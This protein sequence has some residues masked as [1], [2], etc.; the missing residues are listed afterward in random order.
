MNAIGRNIWLD[1]FMFSIVGCGSDEKTAV[2]KGDLRQIERKERMAADVNEKAVLD[3]C[4]YMVG[5]QKEMAVNDEQI[6]A[7]RNSEDRTKRYSAFY[8]VLV[9]AGISCDIARAELAKFVFRD[10]AGKRGKKADKMTAAYNYAFA[11]D[12]KSHKAECRQIRMVLASGDVPDARIA[13]YLVGFLVATEE[14]RQQIKEDCPGFIQMYGIVSDFVR[15]TVTEAED[16]KTIFTDGTLDEE[17]RLECKRRQVALEPCSMMGP[18]VPRETF[19]AKM[20][21]GSAVA[22]LGFDSFK[23][24]GMPYSSS[25][26]SGVLY[27]HGKMSDSVRLK[28]IEFATKLAER[29]LDLQK[30]NM[31]DALKDDEMKQKFL[32]VQWRIARIATIRADYEQR[33]GMDTQALRSRKIAKRLDECNSSLKLILS[34]LKSTKE[35]AASKMSPRERLRHALARAEFEK[36]KDAAKALLETEPDDP[37]ANFAIGMWHYQ[38]KRWNDAEKYLLH[39][40]DKKPA[41]PAIWNNLAMI[42]KERGMFDQAKQHALKALSLMPDSSEIKDTIRQIE[43]AAKQVSSDGRKK[44]LCQ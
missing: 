9:S 14:D 22:Q 17:I 11:G 28:G 38:H 6:E 3:L 36:A 19:M 41:E 33:L 44:L 15:E 5:G 10:A 37:N 1:V 24:T 7:F 25:G 39:C 20:T 4:R 40:R 21:N 35:D 26:F 8:E 2:D 32:F 42:Y 30:K 13:R 34:R 31:V 27:R 43:R 29:I 16:A 23:R 18:V 12:V